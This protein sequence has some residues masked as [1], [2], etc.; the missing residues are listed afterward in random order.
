MLNSD[1]LIE[2]SKFKKQISFWRALTFLSILGAIFVFANIIVAE[3]FSDEVEGAAGKEFIARINIE[4]LIMEDAERMERL[5][6]IANNEKIK[7]VIVNINSPGGT[8]VGGESLYKKL[9]ELGEKKPVVSVLNSVAA[10]AAYLTAVGTD[11]I[12]AH[13]GTITG[14][15]GV[16]MEIPNFKEAAEKLGVDFKYI[17]TSPLKG[18]P[19]LF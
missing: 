9:K 16:I 2:R 18:A 15:I 1:T 14:S 17:K 5:D 7:A 11:K 19:N 8:A 4:G 10:S 3:K 12:Y 6:Y 13:E